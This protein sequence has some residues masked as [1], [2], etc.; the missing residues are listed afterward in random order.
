MAAAMSSPAASPGT[1]DDAADA[2]G[3]TSS[4]LTL[5]YIII[6]VVVGVVLYLAVRYGRSL[7]SEWRELNGAGRRA[8]NLGVALQST[9]GGV[10]VVYGFMRSC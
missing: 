1:S 8:G 9:G 4:N 3:I 10:V 7:L 6:A 2:P 5:L